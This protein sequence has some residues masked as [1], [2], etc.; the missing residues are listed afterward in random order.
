MRVIKITGMSLFRRPSKNSIKT[1]ESGKKVS[2]QSSKQFPF[3]H[4]EAVFANRIVA[5][6]QDYINA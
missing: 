4:I 1:S 3:R 2:L 6:E 5:S